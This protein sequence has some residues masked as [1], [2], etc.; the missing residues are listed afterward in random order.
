MHEMYHIFLKQKQKLTSI[1]C[2]ARCVYFLSLPFFSII[3]P[4]NLGNF[5]YVTNY[6]YIIQNLNSR[7]IQI[8]NI[9]IKVKRYFINLNRVKRYFK[10]DEIHS[11]DSRLKITVDNKPGSDKLTETTVTLSVPKCS[12]DDTGEYTLKL[13]NKYG[14]AESNVSIFT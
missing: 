9:F 3:S 6:G 11:E 4:Q 5:G 8:Y 14:E 2:D 13:K 12:K 7:N 1:N 10:G